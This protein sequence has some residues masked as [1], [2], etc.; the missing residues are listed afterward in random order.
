MRKVPV[1]SVYSGEVPD[2]ETCPFRL[3]DGP[4]QGTVYAYDTVNIIEENGE[5]ILK[6]KVVFIDIR[7]NG[8]ELTAFSSDL[9]NK[10]FFEEYASP[11]LVSIIEE[12]QAGKNKNE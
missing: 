5:G 9:T 8:E 2:V 3:D 1:Y 6:Y 11:I 12:H 10:Q 4:F 7:E